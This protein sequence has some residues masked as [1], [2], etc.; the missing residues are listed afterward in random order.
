MKLKQCI[1]CGTW[2]A[3]ESNY[4]TQC[5]ESEF[6]LC[7]ELVGLCVHTEGGMITLTNEVGGKDL[8]LNIELVTNKQ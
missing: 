5:G 6:G 2:T 8:Q 4:C 1:N 3:V 7:G